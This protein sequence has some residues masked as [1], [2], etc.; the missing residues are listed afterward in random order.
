MLYQSYSTA[1]YL[2]TVGE[3]ELYVYKKHQNETISKSLN[4][5]QKNAGNQQIL[6][7]LAHHSS[8]EPD[9]YQM[10]WG[11]RTLKRTQSYHQRERTFE[12]R[13]VNSR[14]RK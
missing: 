6:R 14:S 8:Q 1:P 9:I 5:I 12:S 4:F 2:L 7:Q 13:V 10:D 11:A 3:G